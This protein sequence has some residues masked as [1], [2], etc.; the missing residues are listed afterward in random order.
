MTTETAVYFC[1]ECGSPSIERG[2]LSMTTAS[3]RA[4][5][6]LGQS[7]KLAVMPLAHTMGTDADIVV[8]MVGDLRTLL[9]RDLGTEM[10]RFLQKYGFID[11]LGPKR[12]FAGKLVGRYLAAIARHIIMALIEER[13][14]IEVE[15]VHGS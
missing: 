10:A 7:D 12:A 8:S 5:G 1:P 15:R 4:C 11:V 6:W 13:D 2:N 14:K 3:C 9:S